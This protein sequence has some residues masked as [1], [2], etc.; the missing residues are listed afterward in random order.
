MCVLM[1]WFDVVK[2]SVGH[3]QCVNG[4]LLYLSVMLNNYVEIRRICAAVT[5]SNYFYNELIIVHMVEL[6]QAT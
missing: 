3:C 4:N 5:I 6:G 1:C 2:L